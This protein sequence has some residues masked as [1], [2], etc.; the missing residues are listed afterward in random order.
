MLARSGFVTIDA[1]QWLTDARIGLIHLD[2]NGRLLLSSAPPVGH[3]PA[4]RRAQ[5]R[6][7]DTPIGVDITRH[8]LSVKIGGQARVATDVDPRAG[9]EVASTLERLDTATSLDELRL[10]EANAAAAYWATLAT[11]PVQFVQADTHLIPDHWTTVGPRRSPITGNQRVAANPAHAIVNY[12]YA[13]LE[14]EARIGCATAGLDPAV[15]ILHTDQPYRDSLAHDVME[16]ARPDVDRYVVDLLAGHHFRRTDFYETRRGSC[17]INRRLTHALA[18]TSRTWQQAVAPTIEYVA[19]TLAGTGKAW[20]PSTPTRLTQANRSAGRTSQRKAQAAKRPRAA[21]EPS[22]LCA[23]CAIEV[24]GGKRCGACNTRYQSDRMSGAAARAAGQPMTNDQAHGGAAAERRGATQRRQAELRRTWDLDNDAPDPESFARE[25]LPL[26]AT[27]SI[28]VMA[29][30]TGLSKG[31]CSL[32]RRGERTPH[33]MHWETL[34][35]VASGERLP[36]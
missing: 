12:L 34:A 15:G 18:E 16:A 13:L 19:K 3:D 7:A 29:R 24:S 25:I 4:L 27:V 28:G 8:L 10:I 11:L 26:L 35:D 30:A 21:P 5:A 36:S 32:I 6:A 20:Q 1:I 22:R 17:R 33:P 2:P 31:Y 9:A 14:A 23:D